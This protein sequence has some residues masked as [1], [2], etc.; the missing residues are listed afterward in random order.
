[1]PNHRCSGL[2][3]PPASSWPRGG[4]ERGDRSQLQLHCEV[5]ISVAWHAAVHVAF[6]CDGAAPASPCRQCAAAATFGGC[7]LRQ[8]SAVASFDGCILRCMAGGRAGT[9]ARGRCLRGRL[10]RFGA[11]RGGMAAALP[12]QPGPLAPPSPSRET[13]QGDH[14]NR[15]RH[16]GGER[17]CSRSATWWRA[18]DHR[19]FVLRKGLPVD[20]ARRDA[21]ERLVARLRPCRQGV[22]P[23]RR[24]GCR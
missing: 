9:S 21:A 15:A 19:R 6:F 4:R 23:P 20:A 12:R 17:L 11:G 13:D 24:P 16:C 18:G 22:A 10:C 3:V 14:R 5:S 2:C 1:M 7:I 8:C